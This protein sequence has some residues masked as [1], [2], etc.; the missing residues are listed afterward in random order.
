[1]KSGRYAPPTGT[2]GYFNVPSKLGVFV[3]E[4]LAL[5]RGETINWQSLHISTRPAPRG[6]LGLE[7]DEIDHQLT[8]K[9]FALLR[10]WNMP[11]GR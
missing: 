5:V 2:T 10:D 7:T 8:Q 3:L 6:Q 1:M 9:R 4:M 11:A